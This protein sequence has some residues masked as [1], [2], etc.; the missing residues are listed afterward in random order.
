MCLGG[1]QASER[2]LAL[3][4]LELAT[5]AQEHTGL[6]S[7]D[8]GL[9]PLA[10]KAEAPDRAGIHIVG[11][12]YVDVCLADSQASQRS[13]ALVVLELATA[14]QAPTTGLNSDDAGLIDLALKLG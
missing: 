6:G 3:E 1:S 13:L 9:N 10:L 12:R 4:V 8:A 14:A 5:A 7:G 11:P 2:S